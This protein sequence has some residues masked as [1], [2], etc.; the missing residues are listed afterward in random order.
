MPQSSSSARCSTR[1]RIRKLPTVCCYCYKDARARFNGYLDDYAALIDGLSELYQAVF[2]PRYLEAAIGLAERM[3]EQ[4]WDAD[5][6]G[7][8]YTLRHGS[9]TIDCSS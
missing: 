4:F 9:R 1:H 8:F 7:F 5:A 2:E 6:G 3:L